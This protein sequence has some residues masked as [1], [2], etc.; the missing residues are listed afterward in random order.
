MSRG[1]QSKEAVIVV[2]I[3]GAVNYPGVYK[4]AP[5]SRI[6]DAFVAAGGLRQDAD[7][8]AIAMSMN[9]AAKLIDG[10][11]IYIPFMGEADNTSVAG[12][13]TSSAISVRSLGVNINTASKDEL[14]AL[15]GIGPVTA[16]KIIGGRPYLHI[17]ELVEKKA[18]SQSVFMKLKDQLTL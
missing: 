14:E 7:E 5:S 9:R 16:E 12:D 8:A 15:S 6:E 3:E 18:M 4:L 2:D 11:K 10:A 17:E 13:Q 1:V